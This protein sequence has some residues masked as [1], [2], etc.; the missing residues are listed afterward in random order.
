MAVGLAGH[1]LSGLFHTNTGTA[2]ADIAVNGQ[3]ET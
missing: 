3:P 2:F 1:A